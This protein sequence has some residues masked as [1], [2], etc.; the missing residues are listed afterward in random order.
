M[1]SIVIMEIKKL[2]A[3]ADKYIEENPD[4]SAEL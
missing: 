2:L 3:K 4:W 1:A